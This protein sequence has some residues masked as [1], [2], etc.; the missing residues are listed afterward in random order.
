[1]SDLNEQREI[2]EE[3]GRKFAELYNMYHIENSS[4]EMNFLI[5]L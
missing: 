2:T 4:K 5:G 1:M 3:E